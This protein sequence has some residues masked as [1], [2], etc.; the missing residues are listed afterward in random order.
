[1]SFDTGS[2]EEED[3]EAP[4]CLQEKTSLLGPEPR[5]LLF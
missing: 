4:G 2:E 3:E 5:K 1:M